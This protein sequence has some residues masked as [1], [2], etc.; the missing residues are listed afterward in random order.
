LSNISL[1]TIIII[2]I[3]VVSKPAFFQTI[4]FLRK[5]SE[6]YLE[7]GHLTFTSLDFTTIILLHGKVI[8]LVSNPQRG[9]RGLCIF[10]AFY[11]TQG[12]SGGILTFLLLHST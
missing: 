9:G 1:F 11:D 3:I 4:A 7:L 5:F 6:I 10:I 8:S 12:Y 2:I